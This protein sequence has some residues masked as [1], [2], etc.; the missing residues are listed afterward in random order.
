MEGPPGAFSFSS[1][2][3]QLPSA[4]DAGKIYK[5]D[6]AYDE[7]D[8]WVLA[9]NHEQK[10]TDHLSVFLNAGY[11]R[12]DWY[13]YINGSPTII[14]NS[15]DFTVRF[16]NYPFT[17][18]TKYIGIGVRGDF[19][20]GSVK[21]EY[22]IG[23]DK[24]WFDSDV[25]RNANWSWS[26]T[27]NIYQDNSWANPGTAHIEP[28]DNLYAKMDGWYI[29]DTL[30]ALEDR[31]QATVGVHGHRVKRQSVG[32]D[33][34]I[35]D[36]V[37]PTVAVSYKITPDLMVYAD[38]T[39]SFG[40]GTIVS[41]TQGYANGGDM[42]DPTKTKQREIGVKVRTGDF[43]HTLAYFHI[44]QANT[45]DVYE[46]GQKYLRIDG[47]Q[48]N[49]GLEW[50]FTGRLGKKWDLLGGLMYLDM[51]DDDG[52][53]LDGSAR[54]SGSLG[55]IYHP[56][57]RWSLIG[58]AVYVGS[59]PLNDGV[60]HVPSYIRYDLGVSFK[61]QIS[62]TPV[63]FRA[64]CYNVADENYWIARAGKDSLYH[65]APRTFSLTATISL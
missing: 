6:W 3:T 16:S 41:S 1:A 18:E 40:Y 33:D 54:W 5:P 64:M 47:A 31:L 32:S 61:T 9:L 24:N 10:I 38:H 27:G 22:I 2:V 13:E 23:V 11:H 56:N 36:A 8:N 60:L 59:A 34:Q 53:R 12:E 37:S 28:A 55:A 57:D 62:H 46:D 65:G 4:P 51:K 43:Y 14:N 21:N 50:G 63:T 48:R 20:I 44:R 35:S 58:R 17:Y 39:E 25:G 15:G 19:T 30:K 45:S 29:L 7:Y 42:L 52:K 49:R 26:G